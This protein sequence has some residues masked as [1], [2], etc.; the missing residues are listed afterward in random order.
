MN[1]QAAALIEQLRLEPHPEGGFYREMYRAPLDVD[2][3]AHQGRRSAF[4]SIYFLLPGEHYS[5][6]HRVASD[7]SWFFHK[8][9]GV[10]VFSLV[11]SANAAQSVLQTQTLGSAGQFELTV[12]AGR[13][14]A[15]KPLDPDGF[16]LVSCVVAPGFEFEDFELATRQNLIDEG[17]EKNNAWPLIESLLI[18][19]QQAQR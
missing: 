10:K 19:A 14:F 16:A 8:G 4:T 9:S 15:A 11:P 17:Y 1:Q 13:W 6:W 2:S 12:P 7:E 3:N 5:A 18:K